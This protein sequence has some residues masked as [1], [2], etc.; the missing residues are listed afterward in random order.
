[1]SEAEGQ[2]PEGQEPEGAEPEGAEPEGAEPESAEAEGQEPEGQQAERRLSDVELQERLQQE[3]KRLKVS[4]VLLQ[5]CY[6][7]SSLGY[8][9]MTAPPEER[10]L[11]QARLAI[12]ALRALTPLLEG[13][14]PA[15]LT[16]D[17]SQVTANMQLAY[18]KAVSEQ[19]DE[20]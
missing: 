14:L 8:G 12:D 16:R 20:P 15:E 5:S 10:D 2:E 11:E 3:L 9:K 19:G 18:A 1:V 6:T 7:I 4:D 13:T 17:L